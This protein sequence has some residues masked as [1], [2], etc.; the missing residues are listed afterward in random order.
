M[1]QDS[2]PDRQQ[3]IFYFSKTVTLA[4]GPNQP[5]TQ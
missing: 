4:M 1:I 2:Y 3:D 5:T